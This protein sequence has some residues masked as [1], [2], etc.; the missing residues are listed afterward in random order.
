MLENYER[1]QATAIRRATARHPTLVRT[2]LERSSTSFLRI[3]IILPDF[4]PFFSIHSV[5][6]LRENNLDSLF[7]TSESIKWII[8]LL[9]FFSPV[10]IF[11][12]LAPVRCRP[13]EIDECAPFEGNPWRR[14]WDFAVISNEVSSREQSL[15]SVSSTFVPS[16]NGITAVDYAEMDVSRV[17]RRK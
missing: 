17:G 3:T 15:S 11:T 16:N 10:G 12:L 6:I 13:K 8:K 7:Q 2:Q 9:Y 14:R 1:L 5:P 4:Y